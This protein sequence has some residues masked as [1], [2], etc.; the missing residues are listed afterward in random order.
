MKK[1][2]TTLLMLAILLTSTV[3]MAAFKE[4]ITEGVSI[5]SIKRLAVA[6]PMHYKVEAT[7]PTFGEFTQI[8]YDAGQVATNYQVIS[9][10]NIAA[11][12]MQDTGID[13][14]FLQDE[15][16]RKVYNEHIANYADAYVVVTTANNNKRTQF[17]FEVYDAKS[18]EL[19]YLLTTQN[20]FNGKTAKGYQKSCEE[21]YTKFDAAGQNEIKEAQKQAKK[22]K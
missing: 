19:I 12:I 18:G 5:N 22:K 11:D 8:I 16:S 20:R 9:Y 17:F 15:D 21:F 3:A 4:D 10:D 14:K 13:I 1:F 2:F 7:E 6:L